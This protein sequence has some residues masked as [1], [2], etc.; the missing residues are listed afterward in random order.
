MRAKKA[1]RDVGR[2]LKYPDPE[3]IRKIG[4]AF[5]DKCDESG[6]PY[7]ITGLA[8]ALDTTREVLID[9]EHREDF[10]HVI[11]YLKQRCQN[12]AE[13]KLF[14]HNPTGAIFALKNYGW[15]DKKE[16]E[17]TGKMTVLIESNV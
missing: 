12:Y 2:P 11:K 1:I 7:T 8:L 6:D 14:A 13:K 3:V 5:F 16:V 17:Q 4:E 10:Q 9:Y 15:T